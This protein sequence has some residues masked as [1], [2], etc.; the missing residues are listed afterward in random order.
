MSRRALYK[1]WVSIAAAVSGAITISVIIGVLS[2]SKKPTGTNNNNTETEKKQP[3]ISILAPSKDT[4][5]A[6]GVDSVSI[7]VCIADTD[8]VADSIYINTVGISAVTQPSDTVTK[9]LGLSSDTTRVIATVIST[10]KKSH[11]D[12]VMVYRTTETDNPNLAKVSGTLLKAAT[13]RDAYRFTRRSIAMNAQGIRRTVSEVV[14]VEDAD[15]MIYNANSLSTKSDTSVQTDAHGKWSVEMQPGSY[16]VFALYFDRTNLEIVTTTLPNIDAV[17]AKETKT[18]TATALS[19]DVKPMLLSFLD[20]GESNDEYEFIANSMPKGLPITMA[21]SEP[22]TRNSIG[23]SIRGIVLC[24]VNADSSGLPIVDTIKVRKYWG[25]DG[26]ELRLVPAE[27]LTVGQTYK[28]VVPTSVK[29]LALNKLDNTYYGIFTVIAATE[30]PPFV[31]KA[32]SP[33]NGDTIPPGFPLEV[34]FSRSIDNFSLN[35]NYTLQ[36]SDT[37]ASLKGYFEGK[38]AIARFR[39]N[40]PW[41]QGVTYTF[42]VKSGTKDLLG[43]TL[44]KDTQIVFHVEPK[45]TFDIKVGLEGQIVALVKQFTSAFAAG[46]IETFAQVFHSKLEVVQM[47]NN[48]EVRLQ[49]DKFLQARKDDIEQMNRLSKLGIIAPKFYV[50][51]TGVGQY[52]AAWKLI[53]K[54]QTVYFE[55]LGSSGGISK[56]PRVFTTTMVPISNDSLMFINRAIVYKGDTLVFAVDMSKTFVDAETRDK[57][58]SFFGRLLREQT[59]V[60]TQDIFVEMKIRFEIKN[61]L[62]DGDHDSAKVMM[63]FIQTQIFKDGKHPYAVFPGDTMVSD[64]MIDVMAIQMKIIKENAKWAVIQMYINSIFSGTK[65]KIETNQDVNNQTNFEVK[66]V[67]QTGGINFVRPLHKATGVNAADSVIRF[68]WTSGTRQSR[69]PSIGGYLFA[70][71]N[72]MSGGNQG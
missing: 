34:I 60:E 70:I 53:G 31:V 51:S 32:T 5:L 35:K 37:S 49:R 48:T 17:K 1:Q 21:F 41:K 72:E 47:E 29:D 12:T 42:K 68:E 71:S 43:D 3:K 57:D 45:D 69:Q 28:V 59:D 7:T 50:C 11:A 66:N 64:S 13:A 56:M 10:T 36:T 44:P 16:F 62:V 4:T 40:V 9:K 67:I 18:D 46:D 6:I 24:L 2:C 14:P 30:V 19:D 26:K 58:P 15:I 33:I 27:S 8:N 54:T 65:Q 38:G 25:P 39:K 61:I 63:K 23:D 55:D 52:F 20:R 22:M